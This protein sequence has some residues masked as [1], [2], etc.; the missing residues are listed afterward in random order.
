M[1]VI[2]DMKKYL[3]QNHLRMISFTL[4]DGWRFKLNIPNKDY[5]QSLRKCNCDLEFYKS[6][7]KTCKARSN[8]K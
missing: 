4:T 1:P 5:Q 6:H 2:E 3:L 8:S 7:S